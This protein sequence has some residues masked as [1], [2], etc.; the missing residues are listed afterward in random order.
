M[1]KI[2]INKAGL[3]TTIQDRGRWGYGRYGITVAGAMDSYAMMIANMLVGNHQFDGVLECTF[4]GPEILFTC[5]EII[6]ITGANMNPK[7]N[8]EPVPMWTSLMVK[9]GD[10]LSLT[11]AVSGVRTY[12]AFSRG[13]DVPEIMGSKSTFTRGKL[14]GLNGEKLKDKDEISLGKGA[15]NTTTGSYI[16][17]EYIPLYKKD[18]TIRVVMGP[19][20]DYFTDEGI[21]TFLNSS[22]KI[23]SEADRMGYRLDGPKINHK[24]GADIISD[25]IVFGS[26]QIP[27]H[28]VPI[29]M[30]S[31]RGT[32]GGY[33]KIATVITPDLSVLAQ[34]G[35]GCNI[36]FQR[37]TV[38]ESHLIYIENENRFK[39]IEEFI[40]NNKFKFDKIR[41][42]NLG[43]S[44]KCFKVE[45]NEIE[46][47]D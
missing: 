33:T 47:K 30:M 24:V 21:E 25:G 32:T 2:L 42:F 13:L 14:G 3:F 36:R 6:S 43:I 41:K 7:I 45:V 17:K 9:E 20:D 15:L 40:K 31:D 1:S 12:I 11:G 46:T 22:F 18:N 37:L 8:G 4:V 44:G 34:M 16:S 19:Q 29:I 23:T 28:G 5:D 38:D 10:K 27:G 35:P 26:I 39:Q